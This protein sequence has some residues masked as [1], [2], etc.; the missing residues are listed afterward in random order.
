MLGLHCLDGS[1]PQG[2]LLAQKIQGLLHS[3]PE[4]IPLAPTGK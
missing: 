1:F 2:Q 3:R 4:V